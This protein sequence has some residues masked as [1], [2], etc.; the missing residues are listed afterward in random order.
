[1]DIHLNVGRSRINILSIALALFLFS[2][3]VFISLGQEYNVRS[4]WVF[5]T[6]FVPITIGFSVTL[7]SMMLFLLSQRLD[8]SSSC[9]INTFTAG[10]LLMYVALAQTLSGCIQNFVLAVVNVPRAAPTE[11]ALGPGPAAEILA[12]AGRLG[13]LMEWI[14]G[15]TWAFLIYVAPSVLLLRIGLPRRRKYMFG[16]GY[17]ALLLLVFWI[18]AFPFQIKAQAAGRPGSLGGYFVR[19][20]WQPALWTETVPELVRTTQKP[21]ATQQQPASE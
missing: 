17:I 18:S 15:L 14:I 21:A 7:S 6:S 10:E 12:L 11:L 5:L 16:A 20:F 2:T 19:Q 8:S 1:M 3:G 9:E 13:S 4:V